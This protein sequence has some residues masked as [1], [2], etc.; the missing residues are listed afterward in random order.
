MSYLVRLERRAEREL[1]RLPREVLRAVD[2]K[3]VALSR[4]PRP[5]GTVKL[6]GRDTEGWRLRVGEYRIHFT[7]DDPA[8]GRVARTS[9]AEQGPGNHDWRGAAR[10]LKSARKIP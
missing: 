5:P 6:R 10:K 4:N 2:A 8:S 9:V 7:V 3:L 1:R